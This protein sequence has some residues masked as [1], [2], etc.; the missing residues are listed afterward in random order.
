MCSITPKKRQTPSSD[1]VSHVLSGP[2]MVE[3]IL[4]PPH[5]WL[6]TLLYAFPPIPL[7]PAFLEK[8]RW[9]RVRHPR[10]GP[11]GSSGIESSEN[12][13]PMGRHIP[14]IM[15]LVVVFSFREPGLLQWD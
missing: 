11:I 13:Y 1:S 9:D 10:K 2:E 3:D 12:T 5:E 14:Y 15:S 8:F 4:P 7:L 6:R